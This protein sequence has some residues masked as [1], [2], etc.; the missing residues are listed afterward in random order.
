MTDLSYIEK[1]QWPFVLLI[2]PLTNRAAA[3]GNT[4]QLMA[5]VASAELVVFALANED[6]REPWREEMNQPPTKVRELPDW[7]TPDVRSRCVLVWIQRG[8]QSDD[9]YRSMPKR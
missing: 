7:A 9:W 1:A 8:G 6:K 3:Y 2:D 5:A 4:H